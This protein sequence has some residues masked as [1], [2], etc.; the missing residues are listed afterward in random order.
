MGSAWSVLLDAAKVLAVRLPSAAVS[1][2]MAQSGFQQ[3]P[4]SN[5][6]FTLTLATACLHH[7][8]AGNQMFM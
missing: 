1:Q 7:D 4:E 5:D 3:R 8:M 2:P 6:G